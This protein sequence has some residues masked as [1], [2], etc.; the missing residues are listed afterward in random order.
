MSKKGQSEV[1]SVLENRSLSPGRAMFSGRGI[2]VSIEHTYIG[3][4]GHV[5]WHVVCL[6]VFA[7]SVLIL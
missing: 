3:A 2:F 5:F 1:V 6:G 4:L 7:L